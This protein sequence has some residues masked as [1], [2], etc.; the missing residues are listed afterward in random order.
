MIPGSGLEGPGRILQ[1]CAILFECGPDWLR[2]RMGS[3]AMKT[4]F[5][6]PGRCVTR[7]G[8]RWPG[9]SWYSSPLLV[10]RGE[11]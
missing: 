7:S 8:A 9:Q 10:T 2:P 1:C 4:V 3:R 5:D 6:W 11:T